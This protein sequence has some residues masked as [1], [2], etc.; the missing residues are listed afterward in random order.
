M[1]Q[2]VECVDPLEGG[3]PLGDGIFGDG[4]H[5]YGCDR[6]K[7]AVG[8]GRLRIDLVEAHAP[9]GDDTQVLTRLVETV[10]EIG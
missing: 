10:G 1:G 3:Q 8:R 9:A 4:V 7:H 2:S 6:D 5:V